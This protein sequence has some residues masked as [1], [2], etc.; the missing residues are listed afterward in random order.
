MKAV[1][2]Q[3]A[4]NVVKMDAW[5]S[6][7]DFR[8]Q[9]ETSE[10][11]IEC[12]RIAAHKKG[13]TYMPRPWESLPYLAKDELG[14]IHVRGFLH[15][16]VAQNTDGSFSHPASLS[17]EEIIRRLGRAWKSHAKK[18]RATDISHHRLVVSMSGEFHNAL[19]QAGRNPDQVIKGMIERTMRSFQEKFHPG[20]SVGYSYGLHHD[21]DNL[22]AHVF[23]HPRTREDAFVGLSGI[24]K[25]YQ[26]RNPN[27]K[28]QL[29]FVRESVRRQVKQ[30]LKELSDPQ[31]AT[32]LKNNLH[33]DR[34]Y[35][36]PRRSHTAR[37]RNDFR[38]RTPADFQLEQKRSAVTS[39][40]RQIAAK[41]DAIRGESGGN[42]IAAIFRLR[43]P[44]WLRLLQK[45]Q[46][47]SL[48]RELRELQAKRYRLMSEYRDARRNLIPAPQS[49]RS[50]AKRKRKTPLPTA[51]IRTKPTI[52]VK[53][54]G[55]SAKVRR[56]F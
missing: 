12:D 43:Q 37:P 10:F 48:F 33:S 24:P 16:R 38:P 42:H 53:P 13:Q 31:E 36:V 35:F 7:I 2:I 15:D 5:T 51:S 17:T 1:A 21:T 49:T 11:K 45:A 20:D 14:Q 41:R 52:T 23:V 26:G 47:A 19:V 28:D 50:V 9:D 40:D 55:K 34:A 22:H 6:A 39:L 56:P 54:T 3:K 27:R 44:K 4:I 46:T 30:V 25:K 18:C 29:G 32:H 8:Y